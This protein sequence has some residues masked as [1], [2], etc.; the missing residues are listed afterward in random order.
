M[1]PTPPTDK[2]IADRKDSHLAICL[3]KNIDY[4]GSDSNGFGAYRFE[5]DALPEIDFAEICLE[6]EFLGK[7]LAAPIIIGSMTGGTA[8][9]AEINRRLALAAEHCQVGM[10][11]GSQRKLLTQRG[12][13]T[14]AASYAV[15]EVAPR[16]PLLF[17]NLGAVQLNYGVTAGQL[18][19]LVEWTRCDAF[20]FHL[21][22]LQEAIQPEGDRNFKGLLAKLSACIPELGVPVF[23]KEVGA[24]I[25]TTTARKLRE[26]PLRGVEVAGSGGT[27]W[28]RIESLRAKG[29][30]E[31]EVGALFA[32]W[33]IPTAESLVVCRR[34]LPQH[35]LV[36]SGGIRNGIEI[37]KSLALG[38]H[39]AAL[40]L[41]LLKAA[42]GSEDE[43][44]RVIQ[45][46]IAE[47]KTA[48][49]VVGV[50]SVDE[51][52]AKGPSLLRAVHDVTPEGGRP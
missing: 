34:E 4:Y 11:L 52:R 39:V 6:T 22:P 49:F 41:P 8:R 48:M 14:V 23:A 44:I 38:A 28:S 15:R 51:L 47:L 29:T 7:R 35:W 17:G 25:S 18:R 21:N 2:K 36:A 42:E 3:E 16:L 43:A 27:S 24:G 10:A 20:N 19:E 40:A 46:L 12:D 26:L 32:Q 30:M 5:H 1:N 50:S 45:R 37:A 33:G 9:A 31:A 13:K